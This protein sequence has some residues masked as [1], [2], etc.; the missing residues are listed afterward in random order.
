MTPEAGWWSAPRKPRI[1]SIPVSFDPYSELPTIR[2]YL[3]KSCGVPSPVVY[4]NVVCFNSQCSE[5]WKLETLQ[6]SALMLNEEA[7]MSYQ[8][9][10]IQIPF[11]LKPPIVRHKGF[12]QGQDVSRICWRGFCCPSCGKLNSRIEI[13]GWKCSNCEYSTSESR[14]IYQIAELRDP[15]RPF[16]TGPPVPSDW[17]NSLSKVTLNLAGHSTLRIARYFMGTDI[18]HVYHIMAS[19]AEN[20]TADRLL[21]DYQSQEIDFRRRYMV[22][23]LLLS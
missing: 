21:L 19:D 10:E 9:H 14:R 4:T 15:F 18:G 7:K 20:A 12:Y 17:V 1:T 2:S 23:V 13:I 16:Y 22:I 6:T 11:D 3:C 5:F 8:M